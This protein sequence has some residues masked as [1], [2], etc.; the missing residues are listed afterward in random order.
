M[1]RHRVAHTQGERVDYS[2]NPYDGGFELRKAAVIVR[3]DAMHDVTCAACDMRRSCASAQADAAVRAPASAGSCFAVSLPSKGHQQRAS[4]SDAA[5]KRTVLNPQVSSLRAAES[6]FQHRNRSATSTVAVMQTDG[7]VLLAFDV[8]VLF[9]L[10]RRNTRQ[11][12]FK[13]C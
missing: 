9:L 13:S 6:L 11:V 3:R 4:A 5:A 2:T 12:R 10:C 1:P 7:A 8:L